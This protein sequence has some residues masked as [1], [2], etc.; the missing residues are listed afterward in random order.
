VAPDPRFRLSAVVGG[1]C[2]LI[3]VESASSPP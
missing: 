1:W 3:G 2:R